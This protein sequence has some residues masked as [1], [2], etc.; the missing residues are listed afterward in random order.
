[1]KPGVVPVCMVLLY[2]LSF[3]AHTIEEEEAAIL[4]RGPLVKRGIET[5]P[6]NVI[7]YFFGEYSF[8]NTTVKV[9]FVQHRIVFKLQETVLDILLTEERHRH[10]FGRWEN[11]KY[12]LAPPQ[13]LKD[14]LLAQ[15]ER[16]RDQ[17]I[18]FH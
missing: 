6:P 10:V 1:M 13:Q 2:A 18:K 11:G 8:K 15:P 17:V 4:L 3:P 14:N 5:L 9:N 7:P 16:T 12:A